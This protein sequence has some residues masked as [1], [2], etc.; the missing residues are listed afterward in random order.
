[1][2]YYFVYRITNVA[3]GKVYI[4]KTSN[5][6]RRWVEHLDRRGSPDSL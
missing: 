4:G 2:A 1:M 5:V 3:N 6:K